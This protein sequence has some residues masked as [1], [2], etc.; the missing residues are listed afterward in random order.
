MYRGNERCSK[1]TLPIK[2]K[3]NSEIF[4]D[5]IKNSSWQPAK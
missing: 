2:I 5:E 4:V 3:D 1:Q